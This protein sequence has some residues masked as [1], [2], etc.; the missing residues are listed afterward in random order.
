MKN[1]LKYLQLIAISSLGLNGTL[2]G[3]EAKTPPSVSATVQPW[4]QLGIEPELWGASKNA[5]RKTKQELDKRWLKDSASLLS[6]FPPPA[7]TINQGRMAAKIGTGTA[8]LA[9]QTSLEP[10]WCSIGDHDLLFLQLSSL[11]LDTLLVSEHRVIDKRESLKALKRKTFENFLTTQLNELYTRFKEK[12]AKGIPPE[13]ENALQVGLKL[14]KESTRKD[15]GS[16]QCLNLLLSERLAESFRVIR[17]IGTESLYHVKRVA[18]QTHRYRRATRTLLMKWDLDHSY[19]K[20][21]PKLPLE[22]SLTATMSES[23]FGQRIV[24]FKQQPYSFTKQNNQLTFKIDPQLTASLQAEARSLNLADLP[25]VSRVY[26]AWIYLD[27]GRAYGLKMKDRLVFKDDPQAIKGQ[28][29]GFYG[30]NLGLK[31]PRGFKVSEGAIVYIRKGQR[32]TKI[33]QTFAFDQTKYPTPFP[34][35]SN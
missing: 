9:A 2:L 10:V 20:G 17:P 6:L 28:V 13:A 3:Q 33:G 12:V 25:Q 34:P 32:Q 29:V 18:K 15:T 31:S 21:P 23:V 14:A 22:Y 26:G 8:S 27:R 1:Y 16:Y 19:K 11:P 35:N 7:T 24:A 4:R 30:P 5:R